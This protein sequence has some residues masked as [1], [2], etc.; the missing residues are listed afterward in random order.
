M[1]DFDAMETFVAVLRKGSFRRAAQSL[2]IPRSTVSQRV[3]RLEERLG[4]RLLERTTRTLRATDAGRAY[5]DRCTRILAEVDEAERAVTEEDRAPRGVLRVASTLLF[6]HAFLSP[7]AAEFA[8]KHPDVEIEIVA[9]N[10]RVSLIE[11]GFDLAIVFMQANEDSGLVARKLESVHHRCCASPA[12][13]ATHGAPKAPEDVSAHACV[14]YGESRD[15]T[16]R[17]EHRDEVR[18]VAVHGRMSVN[19]FFMAHDATLRGVGVASIPTFLCGDD[20]RAGRLVSLFPDWL[21]NRTEMRV[22]YPSNRYLAP[23]VRLF[24]DALIDGY[25]ASTDR[26]RMLDRGPAPRRATSSTPRGIKRAAKSGSSR[27]HA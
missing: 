18:R 17:F 2:R 14:V 9:T 11:E 4:V 1:A 6:G 15:A 27:G 7:I 26:A 19:S 13:V 12:Y 24:V 20:I 16:W 10:R 3:A 23:R 22:V 8:S 25:S 21:L 5:F